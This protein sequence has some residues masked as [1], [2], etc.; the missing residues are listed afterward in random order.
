MDSFE[1]DAD[2]LD[3]NLSSVSPRTLVRGVQNDLRR[4]SVGAHDE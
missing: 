3:G 2:F 1:F 4:R